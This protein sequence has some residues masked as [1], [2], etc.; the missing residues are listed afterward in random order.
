MN[1]QNIIT[2]KENKEE[3]SKT[4]TLENYI[5]NNKN[6]QEDEK[7]FNN[8]EINNYKKNDPSDGSNNDSNMKDKEID[9]KNEYN[10]YNN[11]EHNIE[12]NFDNNNI[13]IDNINNNEY[14]NINTN[15]NFNYN[16]NENNINNIISENNN[17]IDTN[18]NN[19]NNIKEEEKIPEKDIID[20]LI[21]KIRNNQDLG[22]PKENPK[23]AFEQLDEELK[24]GLE[25]LNQI[26]TNSNRKTILDTQNELERKSYERNKKYNEVIDELTKKIEKPSNDEC[27][28]KRGTYYNYKN[29]YIMKPSYYIQTER[30]NNIF[31]YPRK[32]ENKFYMSSIDGKIIVNGERKNLEQNFGQNNKRSFSRE[33]MK[34]IETNNNWKDFG[35][36]KV[37][38]YDKNYFVNELNKIDKLLFS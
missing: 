16:E 4:N 26:K 25:Q 20:E 34:N 18:M 36:R 11:K 3:E 30:R 24:L 37:Y 38:Y 10:I 14:A 17:N 6:I 15:N 23:Q 12:N 19:N 27:Q 28:Y 2:Y 32:N 1:L 31:E 21:E 8:D 9:N 13:D 22:I 35:M 29:M 5:D 33:K 7:D